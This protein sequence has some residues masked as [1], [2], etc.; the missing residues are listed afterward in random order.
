MKQSESHISWLSHAIRASGFK[1]KIFRF[2][3]I[4]T[5]HISSRMILFVGNWAIPIFAFLGLGGT[6]VEFLFL[7]GLNPPTEFHL[8]DSLLETTTTK[9]PI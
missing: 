4:D 8:L 1:G 3:Q 5:T 6:L 7:I 9:C 2:G